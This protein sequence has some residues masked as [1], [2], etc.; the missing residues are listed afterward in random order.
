MRKEEAGT[1]AA[2]GKGRWKIHLVFN[3]KMEK[4]WELR[5]WQRRTQ[6][7]EGDGRESQRTESEKQ[8]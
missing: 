7:Q 8:T 6:R 2:S 4:G 1:L 3:L 5:A